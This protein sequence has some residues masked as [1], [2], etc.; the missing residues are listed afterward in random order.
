MKKF[1]VIPDSYKST[2]SSIEI[3]SIMRK[4]ILN[5]IPD[6]IVEDYP[7]ADG[8][9]GTVD[10]FLHAFNC[11][12]INITT[13][14]PFDEKINTYYAIHDNYAIIEMA[15]CAGLPLAEGKL[16]P[17]RATT[18]GLGKIIVDAINKGVKKIIIGL[19]GSATNDCGVG[20]ALALGTK[21]YNSNLKEFIPTPDT[22]YKI[23]KIDNTIPNNLLKDIEVVAMCDIKNP[24]YGPNGAAY[25]FS[26]QKGANKEMVK[27]LDDNLISISKTIN[28][29]LNIDVSTTPGAG[30]AGGLGA[31]VVAFL[32][33]KLSPGIDT[34]LNL[35]N[36]KEKIKDATMIFTGEGRIDNQSLGGKV[37]V[38][39][40]HQAKEL[41]IPVCAVCGSIGFLSNEIYDHGISSIFSINQKAVDFSISRHKSKENLEAT[42]NNIIRFYLSIGGIK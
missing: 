42:M 33:G 22:L 27:I 37:V 3:C 18:Y 19:G 38:G 8:G 13:T 17:L 41:N 4:S 9:E 2:L 15:C 21:F 23:K 10:C 16:N 36:F 14:G 31:G 7:I 32:N 39:I 35:I 5:L 29:S 34:I 30:A 12:K 1:I 20:M 25:I 6:A 28:D 26:P 40:G 24:L 11:K